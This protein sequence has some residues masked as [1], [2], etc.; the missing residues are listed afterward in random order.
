MASSGVTG[1]QQDYRIVPE[2]PAP[3]AMRVQIGVWRIAFGVVL[4]NLVSGVILYAL[5]QLGH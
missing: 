1:I 5:Y 3:Q 4:G 2:P